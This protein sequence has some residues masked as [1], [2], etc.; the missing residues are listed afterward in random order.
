MEVVRVK[1]SMVVCTE[2]ED[3]IHGHRNEMLREQ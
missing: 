1:G 3:G 2:G